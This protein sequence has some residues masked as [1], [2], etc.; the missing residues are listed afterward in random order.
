[1]SFR[2]A[3]CMRALADPWP[4]LW[5][6][7][8][9]PARRGLEPRA[10]A[11]RPLG[12]EAGATRRR[13]PS[14][15]WAILLPLPLHRTC[16]G[17]CTHRIPPLTQAATATAIDCKTCALPSS[18]QHNANFICHSQHCFSSPYTLLLPS[19]GTECHNMLSTSQPLSLEPTQ[20]WTSL[21]DP[22][23][24]LQ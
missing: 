14:L 9:G 16:H 13:H 20:I 12:R 22:R 10:A 23:L 2:C 1:M 15:P 21:T 8:S 6:P 4:R 3:G 7:E 24:T 19:S 5:T 18:I 11:P 17:H